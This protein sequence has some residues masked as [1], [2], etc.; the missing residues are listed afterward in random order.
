LELEKQQS[1]SR[2]KAL[3][4]DQTAARSALTLDQ[5]KND[6]A[7]Q[8]LLIEARIAEFK[9][10]QAVLDAESNALAT[11]QN[12][13]KAIEAANLAL[14]QAKAQQPGRERDR[15]IADAEA[16]L[17]IAKTEAD[18]NQ[19]NAAQGIDLAKQQ[20]GF[21]EQNTQS[22]LKQIESANEVKKLQSETL[23]IQQN[24]VL[25]QF[26]AAEAAKL[27]ANELE[28][29]RVAAEAIG[30][31][32]QSQQIFSGQGVQTLPA[33]AGGG[34]VDRDKPYIVGENSPEVFVPNVSGTVLNREQL[35]KNFGNLGALNLNVGTNSGSSNKEVV[36]AVRSLEQT[37]QSRPPSP[38]VANFT[39]P[40]DGGMDKLF[41]LQRA[42][43]RI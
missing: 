33:R 41:A 9:A 20:V 8:R 11:Q 23:T 22:A 39:A 40:D 7:N 38:I 17:A 36:D 28:R 6:L 2:L 25:E 29:A 35:T 32:T 19:K 1:D 15:S 30:K 34:S 18:T 16:K 27:Y 26:R 31:T 14:T 13:R 5:Q 10:K 42:S 12:N 37:I 4:L 43:L 21:A 3:E 24:T